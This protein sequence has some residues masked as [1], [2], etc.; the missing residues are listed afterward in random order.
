MAVPFVLGSCVRLY[1]LCS[2]VWHYTSMSNHSVTRHHMWRQDVNK[3]KWTAVYSVR[4][5]YN[6]K[7]STPPPLPPSA[8]TSQLIN[9]LE[10][11]RQRWCGWFDCLFTVRIKLLIASKSLSLCFLTLFKHA[12]AKCV[13]LASYFVFNWH[14]TKTCLISSQTPSIY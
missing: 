8:P 14:E 3:N 1:T 5:Q 6:C 2:C 10:F 13:N 12:R 4:L 9:Y 11:G 7:I